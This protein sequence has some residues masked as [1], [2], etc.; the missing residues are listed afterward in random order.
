[1][2]HCIALFFFLLN[3]QLY[4]RPITRESG[5]ILITSL[6]NETIQ[7]RALEYIV[8]LAKNCNH[9]LIK[10]IHILYDTS[11]EP[12]DSDSG[13]LKVISDFPVTVTKLPERPDF[14][15]C[16][17]VANTLYNNEAIIMCNAD[18]FFNETLEALVAYDLINSFIALSRWDVQNNGSL[19]LYNDEQSQDTWI[20]ETPLRP[21]KRANFGIGTPG[22]DNLIAAQARDVG[23]DVTNPCLTIQGCHVHLSQ[24]R[25][26]K[27][28]ITSG[29]ILFLQACSLMKL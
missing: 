23:Y 22:C 14:N 8:C 27:K 29:N 18:I 12:H 15:Y 17:N 21:F 1:M 7:E 3:Q 9:P 20:F 16:F 24:I 2:I 26:Y 6:Y 28:R 10:K 11:K 5:F 19:K 13:F 25:H 4:A